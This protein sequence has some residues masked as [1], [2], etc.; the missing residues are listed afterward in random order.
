LLLKL[1][2]QFVR[3]GVAGCVRPV[4]DQDAHSMVCFSALLGADEACSVQR[5]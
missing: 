5:A 3:E 1:L 2:L 4:D